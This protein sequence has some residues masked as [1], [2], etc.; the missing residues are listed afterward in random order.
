M[1][2][3]SLILQYKREHAH[4]FINSESKELVL[5]KHV[6]GRNIWNFRRGKLEKIKK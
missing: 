1:I 2:M 4:L 6:S 3:I 5:Q